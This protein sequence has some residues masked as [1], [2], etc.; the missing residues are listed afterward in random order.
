VLLDFGI[1]KELAAP[2]SLT[3]M[4]GG[5]RVRRFI[6]HS[7]GSSVNPPASQQIYESL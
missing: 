4:D 1:A 2:A 5:V 7:S 3:T 6:W